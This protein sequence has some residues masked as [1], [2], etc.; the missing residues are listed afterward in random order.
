MKPLISWLLSLTAIIGCTSNSVFNDEISSKDGYT[1]R[2]TVQI[3]DSH[4][5]GQIYV[6]LEAF[7]L[8]TWTDESGK[9]EI[10]LPPASAQSGGG[11]SGE[12][13]VFYYLANYGLKYSKIYIEKGKLQY[14]KLALDNNGAIRE[15]I[16]LS[17][18]LAIT[19]YTDT[20]IYYEFS[21]HIPITIYL[22]NLIDTVEVEYL[23]IYKNAFDGVFLLADTADIDQAIPISYSEIKKNYIIAQ[24]SK[25]VMTLWIS[26]YLFEPGNYY[27]I[28]FIFIKQKDLPSLLLT[29][30]SEQY[31][32][33]GTEYLKLPFRRETG[34]LKVLEENPGIPE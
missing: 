10:I 31:Q 2:G 30:I 23:S 12:F 11:L 29:S 17:K 15:I 9:Y 1:F 26:K 28:P 20:I 24:P 8:G 3:F 4:D 34:I 18:I 27:I 21:G 5:A 33:F 32:A 7:N 22:E 6:W 19:T 25:L 14:G 13:R 16:I